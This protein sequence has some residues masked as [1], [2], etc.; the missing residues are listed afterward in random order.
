MI[1]DYLPRYFANKGFL[2]LRLSELLNDKIIKIENSV[3]VII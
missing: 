2:D 3:Y 1:F